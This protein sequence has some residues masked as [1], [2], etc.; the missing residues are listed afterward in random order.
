MRNRWKMRIMALLVSAA[1]VGCSPRGYE[2]EGAALTEA[3][4]SEIEQLS[5]DV[6]A[7]RATVSELR[8]LVESGT[9]FDSDKLS[10]IEAAVM[11]LEA[12]VDDVS[13][14]LDDLT[15]EHDH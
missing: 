1:V 4:S 3:D 5:A 11:K 2:Y 9:K 6:V 12:R 10:R 14:R 8:S 13:E 15:A 7:T